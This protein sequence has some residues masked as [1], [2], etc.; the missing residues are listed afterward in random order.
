MKVKST[1]VNCTNLAYYKDN[2]KYSCGV[3]SNKK[4]RTKLSVNPNKQI[5]KERKLSEH[6]TQVVDMAALNVEN[7]IKG[8]VQCYKMHMMKAVPFMPG[9]RN[10]FPNYKH[11]NRKDGFGCSA[12]SPMS[13]GPVDM[14]L[15]DD[16]PIAR[17]IENVI[18]KY[19]YII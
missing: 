15:E 16:L 10:V 3:H 19:L 18:Y 12:L 17:N 4:T 2:K 11:Q 14:F 7:N 5:N 1:G 9:Y 6:N 13:L 8:Q